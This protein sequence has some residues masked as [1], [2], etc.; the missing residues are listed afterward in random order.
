MAHS[1]A[2]AASEAGK[3]ACDLKLVQ[4]H[5]MARKDEDANTYKDLVRQTFARALPERLEL[6][7]EI[8]TLAMKH[9]CESAL[10]EDCWM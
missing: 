5:D 10:R 8:V 4:P 7:Q 1:L 3:R 2:M 9:I 6:A